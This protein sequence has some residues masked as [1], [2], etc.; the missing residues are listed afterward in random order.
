M[1][2]VLRLVVDVL[3]P[4]DPPLYEFT[5]RL[6]EVACVAG[7]SVTLVE[8]DKDVQNVVVTVEG[9]ALDYEEVEAVVERLGATIH[10]IDQVACGEYV[11]EDRGTGQVG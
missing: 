10:S 1:A 3:K 6:A 7:V 4:H 11:V 8:L 9:D 2:P 5:S